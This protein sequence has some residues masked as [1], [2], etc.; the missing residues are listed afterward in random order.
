MGVIR[1]FVAPN[2]CLNC[3][4]RETGDFCHL[5][6]VLMNEFNMMGHLTFYPGNAT[7]LKEGQFRGVSILFATAAPSCRSKPGTERPS[8]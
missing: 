3:T 4:L 8:F 6:D 5:P 2:D 1:R 7:L